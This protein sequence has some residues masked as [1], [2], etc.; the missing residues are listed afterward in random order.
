MC[1]LRCHV[2]GVLCPVNTVE[3]IYYFYLSKSTAGR[4]LV[5]EVKPEPEVDEVDSEPDDEEIVEVS[6]ES[7]SDVSLNSCSCSVERQVSDVSLQSC[8][9]SDALRQWTTSHPVTQCC[10]SVCRCRRQRRRRRRRSSDADERSPMKDFKV[11][12]TGCDGDVCCL[13]PVCCPRKP[14]SLVQHHFLQ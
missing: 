13:Q 11:M 9:S 3:L 5:A 8:N 2:S 14:C 4:T 12:Y 7:C 10:E 1:L 6:S